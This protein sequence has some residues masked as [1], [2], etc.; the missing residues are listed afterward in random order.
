LEEK[1]LAVVLVA[2]GATIATALVLGSYAGWPRLLRLV[3]ARHSW[4]WLAVCLFG[5]LV[6]YLGYVLTIRDMARVDGGPE[7][8]LA[9]STTTVVAGFGQA[10]RRRSPPRR[11]GRPS[12]QP[13]SPL[14]SGS[15][16]RHRVFA[17][18]FLEYA[19]LGIGCLRRLVRAT[20]DRELRR[21][22]SRGQEIPPTRAETN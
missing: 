7:M 19:V 22:R 20:G 11:D 17:L 1:P 3:H 2:A 18:G 21:N 5:E 15:R 6:A 4:A 12:S 10:G 8:N 9:A 14:K 16:Q 13:R